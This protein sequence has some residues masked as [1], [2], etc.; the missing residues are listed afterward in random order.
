MR[1]LLIFLLFVSLLSAGELRIAATA[2]L[3]GNL[4][5]LAVL[6]PELRKCKADIKVDAGD[7]VGGNQIAEYDGGRS[8]IAALN[9][10][11]FDYRVPGN[12]DFEVKQKD[13]EA[14]CLEFRGKNLGGDWA[15]GKSSGIPWQI[16][17]KGRFRC[18]IIGLT[19]P[20]LQRRHLPTAEAPRFLPWEKVLRNAVNE[21]LRRKVNAIVLVWHNGTEA[22]PNG[23]NNVIRRFPEIDL[24]IAAHSH[25]E[26]PGSRIGSCYVVQ[27]GAY[28]TAAAFAK[29]IFDDRTLK[30]SRIESVLLRGNKRVPDAGLMKLNRQAAA[31]WHRI[32]HGKVCCKG[33]LAASVF[34]SLGAA[35]IAAAGNTA[36]AVFTVQTPRK[37]YAYLNSCKDLY[38]LL[39]FRNLLCTVELSRHELKAL[40]KELEYSSRRFNRRV[41]VYGFTYRRG[42]GK[43]QELV[44]PAERMSITVSDFTMTG[45][46]VLRRI[47]AEKPRR[48]RKLDVVERDAVAKY[49]SRAVPGKCR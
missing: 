9:M 35:A 44:V 27:P 42:K 14:R 3:H 4:R 33:D 19:E 15:W 25:R 2:D 12:H 16:F 48:W 11:K 39:P 1:F 45:S 17:T 41:G 26:N 8:M 22:Y 32:I 47:I 37:E 46:A 31:P 49:L 24:V 23:I 28:G 38:R 43:Q 30:I 36:G 5:N 40:M 20:D 18:G 13:F 10:L 21:L 34:P 6:A 7:L 29:I